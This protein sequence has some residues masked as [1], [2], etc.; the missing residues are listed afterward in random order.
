MGCLGCGF[1]T[2]IA[3]L[4]GPYEPLNNLRSI[5]SGLQESRRP[6]VSVWAVNLRNNLP[7]ED[8]HSRVGVFF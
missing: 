1:F 2:H 8:P 5:S 3:G 7:G 6:H 4:F